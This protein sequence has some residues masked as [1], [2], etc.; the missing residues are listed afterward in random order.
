MLINEL[1][2]DECSIIAVAIP[3]LVPT[4]SPIPI[5]VSRLWASMSFLKERLRGLAP[6]AILPT[7]FHNIAGGNLILVVWGANASW[8]NV[9]QP[10]ITVSI[11]GDDSKTVAFPIAWS[12]GWTPLDNESS[13]VSGRIVDPC[14]EATIEPPDSVVDVPRD[15]EMDGKSVSIVSPQCTADMSTCVFVCTGS[16]KTC[17][18]D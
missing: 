13:L 5:S 4:L 18:T 7:F 3:S 15:V 1:V 16:A 17:L 12:G 14:G 2:D 10:E 11:L 6:T 8:V 9:I